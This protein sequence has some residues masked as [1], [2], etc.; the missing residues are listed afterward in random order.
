MQSSQHTRGL[1]TLSFRLEVMKH[2]NTVPNIPIVL[3]WQSLLLQVQERSHPN[4]QLLAK[5]SSNPDPIS[6]HNHSNAWASE[7][8]LEFCSR[9]FSSNESSQAI[10]VHCFLQ[11]QLSVT[12]TG[13]VNFYYSRTGK[14]GQKC[15]QKHLTSNVYTHIQIFLFKMSQAQSTSKHTVKF[16][17]IP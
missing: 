16:Y 10:T 2:S 3:L 9:N 5:L 6:P 4:I 8:Q 15:S 13:L 14:N 17:Q 7:L 11:N 1:S 12:L